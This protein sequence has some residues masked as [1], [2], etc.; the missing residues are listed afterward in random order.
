MYCHNHIMPFKRKFSVKRSHSYST[1][2]YSK[3]KK[4]SSMRRRRLVRT[5]KSVVTR[6]AE[7]KRKDYQWN[8]TELYHNIIQGGFLLNYGSSTSGAA[9]CMPLQGTK[10]SERVGDEILLTG[11]KLRMLLGQKSDRPNVSFRYW[12]LSVPK[13][14]A[15]AYATWF[16][17]TTNNVLLDSVNRDCC[18]ILST[19]IWRPNEAGLANSGGDEYTFVKQLWIPYR[20]RIAFA[21]HATTAHSDRDIH[22]LIA[23]YDAY[24]SLA[25]DN[26]AYIQL[27][28]TMYYRDP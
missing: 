4:M 8:K 22:F 17:A 10:D 25:T 16:D 26:V 11:F 9:A 3:K 24:G 15:Y 13:G 5:I 6:A 21:P 14:Y 23:P 28:S 19:G 7:P 20:K 12:V 27:I 18:I 2:S 1:M